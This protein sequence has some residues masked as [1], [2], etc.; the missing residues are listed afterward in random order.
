MKDFLHRRI[1]KM[2]LQQEIFKV[3]NSIARGS[4]QTYAS[5]DII[6]PDTKPDILK[7]IQ[8]DADAS[9]T[10]KNIR[11]EKLMIRG[12]VNLKILYIPDSDKDKISSINTNFSFEQEINCKNAGE[13]MY[14]FVSANVT[15]AEFS[16]T[17]SRKLYIKTVVGMDYEVCDTNEIGIVTDV[18][19]EEKIEIK[20]ESIS[21]ENIADICEHNFILQEN[22]ELPS[23][24]QPIAE[25]LK[26]DTEFVDTEYKTVTGRIIIKG[27][28]SV[29]ILYT[30]AENDIVHAEMELP[31]TEVIDSNT[32][33]NA[34]CEVVYDI[35]NV[36]CNCTED[37]DGD[38]RVLNTEIEINA[39]VR[40]TEKETIDVIS[41]CYVPMKKTEL[42]KETAE[43][44]EIVATPMSK[45]TLKEIIEFPQ[46]VPEVK[47]IYNAIMKP[48]VT[49][50]VCD[51]GKLLCEGKVD[52]YILYLS[53]SSDNPVYSLHREIPFAFVLSYE[54]NGKNL[55]PR[56][57]AEVEHSEYT[58]NTAGEVELRC[59]LNLY[60]DIVNERN[61][62]IITDINICDNEDTSRGICIYFVQQGDNL[63]DI[64]KHYGVS[65]AMIKKYNDI[66]EDILKAGAKL[67]IPEC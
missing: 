67:F 44:D 59:I 33:D 50:A 35:L 58:L 6:V 16:V 48:Y 62:E 20:R 4:V 45:N 11:N 14:L 54:N 41:D 40:A 25:L 47:S 26:T 5:G 55:I 21:I 63:W 53:S 60:A 15:R 8:V 19:G 51:N 56:V 65:R 9:I 28:V 17:N 29:C 38:R 23:G 27:A 61:E 43:L 30:T 57:K 7:I 37:S 46:S 22:I 36:I 13:N 1:K 42:V 12:R 49:K 31:F 24:A 32:N 52:A 18:E 10:D 39:Q 3:S 66:E 64:A 34:E 2:E